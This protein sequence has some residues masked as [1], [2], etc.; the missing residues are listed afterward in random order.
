MAQERIIDLDEAARLYRVADD[1]ITTADRKHNEQVQLRHN[2]KR[3]KQDLEDQESRAREAER[4][5][6]KASELLT[7]IDNLA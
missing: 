1:A 4:R 6:G 7:L 5:S 3:A 2:Q